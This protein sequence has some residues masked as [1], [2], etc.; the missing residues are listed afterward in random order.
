MVLMAE[1]D[2]MCNSPGVTTVAIKMLKGV[3][4]RARHIYAWFPSNATDATQRN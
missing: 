2:G 4:S 3:T 1:A